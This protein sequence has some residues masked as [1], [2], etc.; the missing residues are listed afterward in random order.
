M[1]LEVQQL[2]MPVSIKFNNAKA[3]EPYLRD[4]I[5]R[6]ASLDLNKVIDDLK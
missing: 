4:A 5:Q 2:T 1:T 3:S 6:G